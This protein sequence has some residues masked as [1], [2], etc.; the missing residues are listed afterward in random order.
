VDI[1]G[2]SYLLSPGDHFFVPQATMYGL[3]N[4]SVD[5]EAEV[6]FVVIK[7]SVVA[8]QA[9]AAAAAAAA[10]AA[11]AADTAASAAPGS[12]A[13][14]PAVALAFSTDDSAEAAT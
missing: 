4:H 13:S 1:A 12:A 11:S 14:S 7:P 5:T 9:D 3:T 8:Q 2:Q 6:A 10:A